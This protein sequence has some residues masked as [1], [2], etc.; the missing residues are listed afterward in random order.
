[1]DLSPPHPPLDLRDAA[2][3]RVPLSS[4][5]LFPPSSGELEVMGQGLFCMFF[6]C[7]SHVAIGFFNHVAIGFFNIAT[8]DFLM[9]Q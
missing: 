4:D 1:L 8:D 5:V 3:V 9:L 2:V 6:Y 7:F